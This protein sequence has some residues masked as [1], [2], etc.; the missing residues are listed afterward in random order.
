MT[1]EKH[2]SQQS[3]IAAQ[4]I[5]LG[6]L[7]DTLSSQTI[8][9]SS[10]ASNTQN[11]SD[12][13]NSLSPSAHPYPSLSSVSS[14]AFSPASQFLYI[15]FGAGT[16]GLSSS[17][18]LLSPSSS[19]LLLERESRRFGQERHFVQNMN[20]NIHSNTN[21]NQYTK[22][23]T[24]EKT[25][26][27][28]EKESERKDA[29]K[30]ECEGSE[31]IEKTPND[32]NKVT[33]QTDLSENDDSG[34]SHPRQ[35][36]GVIRRIK[37]DIADICLSKVE[38]ILTPFVLPPPAASEATNTS[39]SNKNNTSNSTI[40]S[41]ET[42]TNTNAPQ[43]SLPLSLQ[44]LHKQQRMRLSGTFS[45]EQTVAHSGIVAIGCASFYTIAIPLFLYFPFFLTLSCFVLLTI[46]FTF[47][48]LSYMLPGKSSLD[49]QLLLFCFDINI[50]LFALIVL[51]IPSLSFSF[52]MCPSGLYYTLFTESISAVEPLI[53]P[54]VHCIIFSTTLL[55]HRTNMWK[56]LLQKTILQHL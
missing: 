3:A 48:F 13:Q 38:G 36:L 24:N 20:K 1:K 29:A 9:D 46:F 11:Q 7:S 5:R 14:S 55:P 32:D 52:Q 23:T 28:S 39:H 27:P 25:A 6:L 35:S 40:H 16:G 54:C 41:P 42:P 22:D 21:K 51:F 37:I 53:S 31:K 49:I 2:L 47:P 15:E 8:S 45:T 34:N 26:V 30:E 10:D 33:D 17:F 18:N 12:T 44:N 56:M 4:A 50:P 43:D 19:F